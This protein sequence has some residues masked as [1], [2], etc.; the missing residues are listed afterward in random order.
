MVVVNFNRDKLYFQR[1]VF[2]SHCQGR[3]NSCI[4]QFFYPNGLS[5]MQ[6]TYNFFDF[7]GNLGVF[8]LISSYFALTSGRVTSSGLLYPLTN[9][10]AA[11][12][13]TMSLIDKPN[14]S[15]LIIEFFWIIISLYGLFQYTKA[16]S[17]KA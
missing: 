6:Y 2:G 7:V 13:L 5:T 15:S 12:F 11:I 1:Q 9:L 3:Y 16:G 4:K 14:L 8:L 10:L 17:T